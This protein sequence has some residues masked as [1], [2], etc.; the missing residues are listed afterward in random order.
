[1]R[2]IVLAVSLSLALV[3]SLAS[4]A[5]ADLGNGSGVANAYG[6]RI[7][8]C[9]GLSYGQLKKAARTGGALPADIAW[10]TDWSK[11]SRGARTMWEFLQS[12]ARCVAQ[13]APLTPAP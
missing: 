2:R 1:M 10:P 4:L 13:P 5:S 8:A 3:G 12:Q 11:P 9:T 6:H 7:K